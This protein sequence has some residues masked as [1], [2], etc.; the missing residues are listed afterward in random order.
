MIDQPV[1][2]FMNPDVLHGEADTPL[3]RVVACM[4]DRVQS[5]FIVCEDGEPVGVITE[6]DVVALMNRTFSGKPYAELCARDVMAS[7]VHTLYEGSTMGEVIR[8]MNQRRFRCVPIVDDQQKLSGVVNL[9]EL[10]S[11][12]N[13]ALER[14]GRDLEVAVMARTAELQKANAKLEELSREDSLTGLLNRRAMTAKLE[15]LDALSRRYGNAYSVILADIDHFKLFNDTQGHMAGDAALEAVA[16]V[17]TDAVRESDSVYRYGGE[18]FLVALPESDAQSAALVAERIRGK[19]ATRAIPHPESPL[20]GTL[21]L[22]LGVAE[23]TQL[24]S[25]HRESWEGVVERA[26]QALYRAKQSGRDRVV[27]ADEMDG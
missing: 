27:R 4:D 20:G 6:R 1:S 26:D 25:A 8:V 11:A 18:E 12:M 9:M 22:S 7:P 17:L 19:L 10:Q 13:S 24:E 5:A 2:Q 16:V 14:R 21:T 3:P 23:S 15:E